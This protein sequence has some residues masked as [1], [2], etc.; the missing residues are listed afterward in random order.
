MTA[1]EVLDRYERLRGLTAAMLESAR[2]GE[3]DALIDLERQSSVVLQPLVS[4]NGGPAL[5]ATQR[6]RKAEVLKEILREDAEI[7]SLTSDW[8]SK[9][10]QF[11]GNSARGKAAQQLYR[12]NA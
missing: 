4:A 1:E 10:E 6:Q 3:W 5:D 11:L 12:G 2:G 9:L 7:R 8:M